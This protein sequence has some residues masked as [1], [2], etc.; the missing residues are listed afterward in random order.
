MNNSINYYQ[1]HANQFFE[2]T[3]NVDMSSIHERFLSLMPKNGKLLDAGCGSGRDTKVFLDRG[4]QVHAFDAAPTIAQL[5]SEYLSHKVDVL[6]FQDLSFN[7]EFDGIWACAS[8]L[9][10]PSAELPDVLQR[11]FRA[12]KP[13]GRLYASFKYGNGETERNGRHFTDMDEA[14]LALLVGKVKGFS[15]MDT[16]VSEDFRPGRKNEYWLNTFLKSEAEAWPNT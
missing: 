1:A 8:L 15:I 14:G 3:L 12:L 7:K 4:Y 13:G 6:R 16:W 9:H 2:N 5:A 10:V 11:M